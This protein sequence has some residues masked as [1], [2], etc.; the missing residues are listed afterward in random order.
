M[1]TPKSFLPVVNKPLIYYQ[2]YLLSK[3]G[4]DTVIL[5]IGQHCKTYKEVFSIAKKA[6]IKLYI[7]CEKNPLGT[8]GGIKNSRKF[9]KGEKEFFVFNGDIISDCDLEEMLNFHKEKDAFATICTTTVDNP[10]AFGVID[11]DGEKRIRAF[12]EKPLKPASNIINAGIYILQSDILNEIP[13]GKETS[14]EKE[15]FPELI[16]KGK[17]LY[18][19][20]H[21]GYWID[22]GTIENYKK[23]NFDAIKL[24]SYI[25]DSD[26]PSSNNNFYRNICIQGSLIKGKNIVFGEGVEIRGNVIIGDGCYIGSK[27]IIQDSILFENVIIGENSWVSQSIIGNSVFIEDNCEV[28]NCAIADSSRLCRFSKIANI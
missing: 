3:Y 8:A 6:G 19:F 21:T 17:G 25:E 22:V 18:A 26:D 14:I 1:T 10:S 5:A 15:T 12:I 27:A 28:K 11:I 2:F 9:L 24:K 23:A 13:D 4:I 16:N 20:L 7:S